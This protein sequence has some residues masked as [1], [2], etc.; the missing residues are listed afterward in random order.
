MYEYRTNIITYIFSFVT[1]AL[2]RPDPSHLR[3]F[4]ITHDTLQSAGPLW[5][6]DQFDAETST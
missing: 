5:I 4:Y 6:G 2:S 1:T 3:G